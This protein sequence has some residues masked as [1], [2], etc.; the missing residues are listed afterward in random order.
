MQAKTD[1][2][3]MPANHPEAEGEAAR[4]RLRLRVSRRKQRLRMRERDGRGDR[5]AERAADRWF[6]LISPDASPASC[7]ST[8]ASAAIDIGMN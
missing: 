5:D 6:A 4:R 7:G 1:T 2:T 3:L 8:P